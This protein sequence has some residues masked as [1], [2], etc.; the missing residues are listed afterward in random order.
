V[1]GQ[2]AASFQYEAQSDGSRPQRP[3]MLPM[4]H[5]PRLAAALALMNAHL[6]DPLPL[7]AIARA[8][9][10]GLRRM[11]Q[12]FADNLGRGPAAAYSVSILPGDKT[13]HL[14]R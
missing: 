9:G 4:A 12:L 10:L 1:A 2:V 11:E 6:E 13:K 3:G 8:Q 14:A 5:D 7:E